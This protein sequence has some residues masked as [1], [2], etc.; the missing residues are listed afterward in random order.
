M[1]TTLE[2]LP[3][4][5]A[6]SEAPLRVLHLHS[7]NMLGGI[8]SVLLTIA[9]CS[10]CCPEL[11]QEF[12]LAFDQKFA[13]SLRRAG[14]RLHI[15]SSVKLRNPVSVLRSRREL[16]Q[17]LA[18]TAYD[19]VISHSAW[20]QAVYGSTLR[21]SGIPVVFWMHGAFDGHWLQKLASRHKPDFVICNSEYTRSTL[22]KVY[23]RVKSKVVH[24]PV[25]TTPVLVNRQHVRE[26]LGASA[27]TV[28]ILM[29]SRMEDWKGHLNLIHA[30][31]KLNTRSNWVIWIAGG[32]Q[33]P[34]EAR[35]QQSITSEIE[36]LNLKQRI[37]LLGQRSDV[38]ALM[39]A[40]DI[41]CQPNADPEPFGVVFIE[42]LQAGLPV[43]T[44]SMG[45]P[46]EILDDMSGVLVE[47]G[48]TAA[49]SDSLA[50]LIDDTNLRTKFREC[51]PARAKALCDPSQQLR[52]LHRVITSALQLRKGERA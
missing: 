51:G 2:S 39:R 48:D 50:K 11:S 27:E 20:T 16:S 8:E 42:A 7:G 10:D 46:R 13:E 9:E 17:L 33:T 4:I 30:A 26:E 47:P 5:P 12:A 52:S 22:A 37:R 18:S 34:S 35:Y 21:K 6:E 14:A 32:S 44:Y 40:A 28:V 24:Y 3:Q 25:S 36:R 31:A 19:V 41:F 45:G 29:A 23:S 15:L 49:L 38:L 43:V 1:N